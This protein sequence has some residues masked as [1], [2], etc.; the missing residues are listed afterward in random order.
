MRNTKPRTWRTTFKAMLGG[1]VLAL[2]LSAPAYA[3]FTPTTAPLLSSAAVTPNVMLL[4]DNSGSMNN[5]IRAT[6]FDQTVVRAQLYTC[7]YTYNYNYNY[8]NYDEDCNNVSAQNMENE[9]FFLANLVRTGCGNGYYAFS[10]S[11]NGGLNNRVCLK[12]PDPVG[13][14]NTRYSTRYLSY[15]IGL[16]GPS[17][18]TKDYTDGSIPTDYRINVARTVSSSLVTA[19][20]ALRMGLATFN[21]PTGSDQGP[22]GN[23]AK[24]ISDLQARGDTTAA[25]ANTNYNSLLSAISG[26]SAQANTPLAETY[27]EITRYFR[28]LAPYYNTS[29]STYTSPIQYRCQRNFG[30]VITDGL[31]TYDRTFP[32]KDPATTDSTNLPNWD[33]KAND[34]D[35]LNG[36][37]EGD[38]LYLDD[39]AKFAYDIDMR[40]TGTDAAAKSW[41]ATDFPK[42]NMSTYTVGFTAANEMLSDAASYGRGRYYQATDSAT[43][44]AALTQALNEISSKAGS[45]GGGTTASSVTY[46]ANYYYQSL[47][48]P[49]D[50]SGT[51]RAYAFASDGTL[52]TNG[53]PKW[54]TD[55]TMKVGSGAGS[56]QSWNTTTNRPIDL[57]FANFSPTQQA[58]LT[59][60]LA[61]LSTRNGTG[62]TLTGVDLIEWAK[63]T[64]KAGLKTRSLL[65]GDVIDSPVVLA[66]ATAQTASD[67]TG[68]T[69]YS[70]YLATKAKGMSNTI[71][72]NANDG[73]TN[74]IDGATGARRFAY[75]PSTTLP[76]LYQVEDPTYVDGTTHRF[77]NDGS[78]AV[79]DAQVSNVWKTIAFGGTGGAAKAFYAIQLFD[80]SAGDSFKALWE[81]R[82]PDT[83][84]ASNGFNDLGYAYARPEVARLPDGTW[85]AF[86]SNGYGSN[87]GVAALYVVNAATG[88]LIKEIVVD[89]TETDNGLSSV[90]LVVNAANVVQA[91]YG[92]DLKGRM[93]KFD[94]SSTATSNWGVAFSGKPLFTAPG[95]ASQPITAQPLI[96][97]NTTNGYMVSFGTGKFLEI[98]DKTSS[99]TQGFYAIW[100]ASN[101]TGS[102]T[103]N[104]LQAQ[105]ITG[106]STIN[107][108]TYLTVSQ[109]AVDYPNKKGWYLPLSYNGTMV[110]ERVIYQ[111]TYTRGRIVFTTAGVDT[112][113]PCAAQ[114]FGRLI[115]LEAISGKMLSYAVIDTNG[116]GIVNS[117]DAVSAGVNFASGI[118]TLNA[119]VSDKSG[120]ADTKVVNTSDAKVKAIKELG[121]S[122]GARR[123]MWR[124]I[125]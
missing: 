46:N 9:N 120:T 121:G 39:V 104:D 57:A 103:V 50:W 97:A 85:A 38:T 87:T 24:A 109:N 79:F 122:G 125:Q 11:A 20:R 83:A 49:S 110:G 15:L 63:G 43:L 53:A 32:P 65:L 106:T 59:N 73:F 25:Q 5:V 101:S 33:N 100:D 64:N 3:A 17:V 54:T 112:S 51:L 119:V 30:V 89:S 58:T 35:N 82:A 96:T 19:N 13:G 12:L 72:V 108:D 44:T 26:L 102:Y 107:G 55:T 41:D 118:P 8:Y 76:N 52:D 60:S 71:L 1:A 42:Q 10:R 69:S 111:A 74:V 81:I 37:T 116:D 113:D 16:L 28:G 94:L 18:K 70:T 6:A 105:A 23:I 14:G 29:P 91:A 48:N 95:G 68:D 7:Y 115:E 86:I 56:F 21:P 47:Y 80:A 114:G 88:A 27:Y 90:K 34:G 93:W 75:L 123:I 36:D 77:L 67:L 124:Q 2:Y 66:S 78:L 84:N 4:V 62:A 45:G 61:S 98:A 22:G 99:T 40:S 92:G 117:D 31:P